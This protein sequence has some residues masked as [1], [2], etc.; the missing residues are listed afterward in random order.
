MKVV[1]SRQALADIESIAFYYSEYASP[2][3]ASAIE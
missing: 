2:A 3:V 1:Y